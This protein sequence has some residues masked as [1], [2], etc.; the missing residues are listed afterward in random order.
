ML[1]ITSFAYLLILS[2]LLSLLLTVL[3]WRRRPA[4]GAETMG[5]LMLA[6]AA[7]TTLYLLEMLHV[8][9]ATKLF[10]AKAQYFSIQAIPTL[11]LVFV[12][13]YTGRDSLLTGRMRRLL[14]VVPVLTIILIWTTEWHGLIYRGVELRVRGALHL[15]NPHY[16]PFFW[17]QSLYNYAIF[18]FA[19]GIVAHN[20][21]H[22]PREQR[23]SSALLLVGSLAPIF[24]NVLYLTGLNPF[25]GVDLT[26]MLFFVT[27]VAA[28]WALLRYHLLDLLPAAREALV[29]N[30]SDA[31]VVVDR[32]QRI[33]DLNSRGEQLTSLRRPAAIGAAAAS[34]LPGWS[35]IAVRLN[36]HD[37]VQMEVGQPSGDTIRYFDVR[38]WALRQQ[39]NGLR[40]WLAVYRDISE[41]KHA[42]FVEQQQ[43]DQLEGLRDA[44]AALTSTLSLDEVLDRILE[45]TAAVI[46]HDAS[47]IMLIDEE[48]VCVMR[49]R[50]YENYSIGD[51]IFD[52]CL[53]WRDY[54]SLHWMYENQQSIFIADTQTVSGWVIQA[55]IPWVRSYAAAPIISRG[56]VIGFLNLDSEQPNF[57][58]AAHSHALQAF[59]SQ[60]GIA[61]ENARLYES[62]HAAN[63]QL[64]A[65]L[66]AR[67]E[68][69]QN[70]SHELRTPL[71]IVLG[72]VEFLQNDQLG[73]LNA[74][75][76]EALDVV[77]QQ[78]RRLQFMI[79]RLLILQ[80]FDQEKLNLEL[81]DFA[82]WLSSA[83]EA[84]RYLA[85]D[86]HV[87]LS[88]NI[89]P[90]LPLVRVATRHME[91]VIANLLDNAVKFSASG[92][93]VAVSAY[94]EGDAVIV[95]VQ[96]HGIGLEAD[97]LESIFH[98]FYQVDG[99]MTRRFGGMGIGLALCRT[100]VAAH[101][102][103]IWAES[104]GIKQGSRFYVSLPAVEE[105]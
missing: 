87:T 51:A 44:A 93:E 79:N 75:Q 6:L 86:A 65:A 17:V 45:Q 57:F 11:W 73:K 56:Q 99:A 28:V 34:A 10:L 14:L 71:T 20:Y 101:R 38:V 30:I 21:R 89:A 77:R 85:T 39:E 88:Y 9:L 83:L 80:T 32:W 33:F 98:H 54:P 49:A 91:M 78:G 50:G 7:W 4:A 1:P 95:C 76:H 70:V 105:E 67:T 43:R 8:Q 37:V 13:Q 48:H 35:D 104:D 16:G 23:G 92:S 58:N 66:A 102:G 103:R 26:P 46:P 3:A 82:S 97:Q 24:G 31:V 15:L 90:D 53:R 64:S 29:E 55:D 59:A 61:I 2:T 36:A 100:V 22:G 18:L 72:Y 27:G 47:N 40:G 94:P 12:L 81:V 62:L 74:E 63:K 84:W 41:S 52:L 68:T 96:D 25:P 19:T 69:I 5:L 42:Q 60:A